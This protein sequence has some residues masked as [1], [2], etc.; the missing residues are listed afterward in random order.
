MELAG[1]VSVDALD[2]MSSQLSSQGAKYEVIAR[3]SLVS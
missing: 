2:L 3:A 1:S